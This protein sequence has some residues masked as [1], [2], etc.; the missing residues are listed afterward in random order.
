[1]PG[2]T[3]MAAR[4]WGR[5]LHSS[6]VPLTHCVTWG[7]LLSL[8]GPIQAPAWLP[9]SSSSCVC[10]NETFPDPPLLVPSPAF[11]L[12]RGRVPPLTLHISLVCF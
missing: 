2:Q 1:M 4:P 11:K 3:G 12:P 8:S 5:G 9:P 10:S 7:K 6:L